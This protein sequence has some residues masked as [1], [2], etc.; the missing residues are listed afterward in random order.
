MFAMEHVRIITEDIIIEQTLRK[1]KKNKNAEW[2][3]LISQLRAT[4]MAT[5]WP[6][7][8][9]NHNLF[10]KKNKQTKQLYKKEGACT[11]TT[12]LNY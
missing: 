1:P 5:C 12:Q 4:M 6:V 10:G 11:I 9:L 7:C 2:T 8:I 3:N